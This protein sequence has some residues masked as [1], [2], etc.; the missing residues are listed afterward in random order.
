MD[1]VV[2]MHKGILFSL[3]KERKLCHFDNMDGLWRHYA[4]W[5]KSDTEW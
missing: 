2:C 3:K 5:N 1:K 4:K